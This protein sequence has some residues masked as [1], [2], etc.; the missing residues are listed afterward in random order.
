LQAGLQ[1]A[2]APFWHIRIALPVWYNSKKDLISREA[3][4]D[5]LLMP[6]LARQRFLGRVLGKNRPAHCPAGT[7]AGWENS[8]GLPR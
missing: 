4:H 3:K 1:P 7:P 5:V 2:I 6:Y 8:H